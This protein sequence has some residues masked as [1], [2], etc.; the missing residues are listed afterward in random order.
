LSRAVAVKDAAELGTTHHLA[1]MQYLDQRREDRNKFFQLCSHEEFAEMFQLPDAR[2]EAR[3]S[4]IQTDGRNILIERTDAGV[5][6]GVSAPH[7]QLDFTFNELLSDPKFKSVKDLTLYE[8]LFTDQGE[9]VRSDEL[10]YLTLFEFFV[11]NEH[12][13]D[14]QFGD[15]PHFVF[16]NLEK[17]SL[18]LA[19]QFYDF[20]PF[21]SALS[22]ESVK[23]LYVDLQPIIRCFDGEEM[24][25]VRW[26]L[27]N[28]CSIPTLEKVEVRLDPR[29][30]RNF[31]LPANVKHCT[32]LMDYTKFVSNYD[33]EAAAA[34]QWTYS[35]GTVVQQQPPP[36]PDT[37]DE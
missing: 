27:H 22:C 6:V 20:E 17:L 13:S 32:L 2:G 9:V 30:L 16:P 18:T 23:E 1:A 34:S 33:E 10:R 14:V 8:S 12:D 3:Y 31:Q 4:A 36:P 21:V 29:F 37:D 28:L 25:S 5:L 26:A 11:G 15:D 19:E 35:D 24:K 7:T